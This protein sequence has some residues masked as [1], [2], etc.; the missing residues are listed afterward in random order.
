NAGRR[1]MI[2]IY[3][4]YERLCE[5]SAL[6]D[7]GELLLRTLEM[8]RQR[9]EL[10]RQYRERFRHLLVDEFQDTNTIQYEWLALLAGDTGIPFVVGDDDQSIYRW[11]GARVENLYRFQRDYPGTTIVRLEQNYRSTET[12]LAAANAVISNYS[13]RLGK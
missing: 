6:L 7:F 2:E 3:S 8:L 5:E 9:P 4:R 11:R 12:I 1:R 13:G 10:L